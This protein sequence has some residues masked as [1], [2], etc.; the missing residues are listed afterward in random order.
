[1]PGNPI[2]TEAQNLHRLIGKNGETPKSVL[3][4][5]RVSEVEREYLFRILPDSQ[6]E[7]E[8]GL[9]Y[10]TLVEFEFLKLLAKEGSSNKQDQRGSSPRRYYG[11]G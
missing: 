1:V 5:I 3:T 7:I 4:L 2:K 8:R 9:S 10:R 11:E 6:I